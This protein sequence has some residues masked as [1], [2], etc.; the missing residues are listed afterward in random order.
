[1]KLMLRSYSNLLLSVRRVTPENQGKKTAGID[2]QTA[3]KP[4]ERVRL[5]KEMQEYHLCKFAQLGVKL[6]SVT[7]RGKYPLSQRRQGF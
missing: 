2:D 4:H 7:S 1:M 6:E 3:L 5:V